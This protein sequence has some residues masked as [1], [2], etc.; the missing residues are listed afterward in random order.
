MS[1][2]HLSVVLILLLVPLV[3]VRTRTVMLII[4][5]QTAERVNGGEF[6]YPKLVC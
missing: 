5:D 1:R 4:K 6:E 2:S 3:S